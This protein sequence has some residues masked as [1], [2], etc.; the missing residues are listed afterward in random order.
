MYASYINFPK[1]KY[2]GLEFNT[3]DKKQKY[4]SKECYHNAI[5]KHKK[6][7]VCCK[8][9]GK[10][11]ETNT[12]YPQKYCSPQCFYNDTKKIETNCVVC[13]VVIRL[14]ESQLKDRNYCSRECLGIGR[15]KRVE[16][17]CEHCGKPFEVIACNENKSIFCSKACKDNHQKRT[18]IK[19]C[20]YCGQ[21]FETRHCDRKNYCSS[22]CRHNSKITRVTKICEVCGKSYEVNKARENITKC[23][24]KKCQAEYQRTRIETICEYC[25]K[26]VSI[27]LSD[28]SNHEHHFCNLKCLGKWNGERNKNR[29]E[30]VCPICGKTYET[31]R[32]DSEK[33][34]T[35]SI[36]C[37][38]E[39]QSIHR[40]GENAANWQGGG[41]TITCKVCNK[42]FETPKHRVELGLTKFCSKECRQEYWVKYVRTS[43][44]FK[45]KQRIGN[46]KQWSNP[47]FRKKITK[48]AL[49]TLGTYPRETSIEKTVREYLESKNINHI[50]QYIIN[51]KFCVDFFL[52]DY[53][54]II[55]AFGDYWHANP[56]KYD[57]ESLNEIQ[58]KNIKSDKA[59]I[60]YLRKCGYELYIFWESDIN[61]HLKLLMQSTEKN[62]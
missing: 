61:N 25:G 26:T 40:R 46:A 8:M 6:I 52:P 42:T 44:E 39:W 17:I 16:K 1:C 22:E 14:Y 57:I 58:I 9:C 35:C 27:K 20:K 60:A 30:K 50:C 53:N 32:C 37:Q 38:A 33:S 7:I 2:C 23:C 59:R 28:L 45:E 12:G 5:R 49:N 51:N 43:K 10:D 31:K 3:K 24:S 4:C 56:E 48:T 34:V 47:E 41:V 36:K 11:F 19:I 13:G 55:E 62:R 18:I 54:I 29:V 21:N 15:Q